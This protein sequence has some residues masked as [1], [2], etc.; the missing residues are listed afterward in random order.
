[1]TQI[2]G[3][4]NIRLLMFDLE[5][6][7]VPK[8]TS[9]DLLPMKKNIQAIKK[10]FGKINAS[11][12]TCGIVTLRNEDELIE[13]LRSIPDC[14]VITAIF[15]KV[16]PVE[17]LLAEKNL[18]FE[19][20]FYMGDDMFDIPLLNKAAISAAPGNAHKEVKRIVNVVI[21]YANIEDLFNYIF[22]EIIEKK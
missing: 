12:L 1:M 18:S 15:D 5:G 9:N 13:Q 11:G 14:S 17:K 21:P 19:N 3:R 22:T 8:N 6:V 10:F 16:S 2:K 20:L 7:L 4:E